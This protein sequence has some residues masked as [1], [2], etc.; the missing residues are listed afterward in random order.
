MKLNDREKIL[1]IARLKL[2]FRTIDG[3]TKVL[4]EVQLDIR[5][6]EAVGLVGETGCGK[7]VTAR[8]VLGSLPIPPAEIVAGEV[9]FEG[10][11]LLSVDTRERK[12]IMKRSM[13]YIPQDPMTSLNPVFTVGQQL[14]DLIKWHDEVEVGLGG[15]L[16]LRGRSKTEPAR[17]E[18]IELLDQVNIPSPE[19]VMNKY[20]VELSGG[21][22][23]RALIA[24]ALIGAPQMLVADEPTT[25][26]DVTI[27]K[28]I[29]ELL[30]ERI[31]A[32]NLAVFYITHNLGV[33]RRLCHRINVMYAGTVVECATTEELLK[34]P[35]HPYSKGLVASVPKLTKEQYRGIEGRLPDYLNPPPGCRFHPRCQY[36]QPICEKENPPLELSEAGGEHKAACFFKDQI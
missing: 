9:V 36:A 25:A 27:Q 11:D 7:S 5:R 29:L 8:T 6:K 1:Q 3:R 34:N 13:S 33:A 23:Q 28:G 32:H 4:K 20:P 15:L 18:G 30:E 16:G 21:M 26:L 22:R 19:E 2:H 24:M 14:T 12:R 35:L 10:T 17:R 31:S